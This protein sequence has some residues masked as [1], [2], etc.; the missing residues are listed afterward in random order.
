[1]ITVSGKKLI[2]LSLSIGLVMNSI[3]AWSAGAVIVHPSKDVTM[4]SKDVGRLFLG[5]MKSF[6]NGDK[7]I[8]VDQ[9]DES[10]VR[11]E[12]MSKVLGK[13]AQQVK[14][15]WSQQIFTGK[16]VPPKQMRSSSEVKELVSQNPAIIGYI[17]SSSVDDSIKVVLEY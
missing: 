4:N 13:T 8:V 10:E 9:S 1:M 12:F 2:L 6:P 14:A 7:V 16:G 15:Y 3:A 5:K 11:D 17:D